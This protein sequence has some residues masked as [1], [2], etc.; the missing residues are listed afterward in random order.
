[1]TVFILTIGINLARGWRDLECGCFGVK[2]KEHIGWKLVLRDLFLLLLS[3]Q[4]AIW[5]GGALALDNSPRVIQRFVFEKILSGA[6]LPA[7]LSAAGLFLIYRLWRT[8]VQLVRT[9][10]TEH[11]R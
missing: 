11:V 6:F 7:G 10:P 3:L 9:L 2:L 5:G 1:M 8:L 4:L